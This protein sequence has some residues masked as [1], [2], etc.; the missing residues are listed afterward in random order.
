MN[1]LFSPGCR[2]CPSFRRRRGWGEGGCAWG[3]QR[4]ALRGAATAPRGRHSPS[5]ELRR[6]RTLGR[7]A[8]AGPSSRTGRGRPRDPE[9]PLLSAPA[10]GSACLALSAPQNE[11]SL[12]AGRHSRACAGP[13]SQP[14]PAAEQPEPG[15]ARRKGTSAEPRRSLFFTVTKCFPSVK[16]IQW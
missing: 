3:E 2:I 7:D 16:A 4:A 8:G 11:A 12:S 10:E 6:S 13:G 1:E 14:T 5:A 15:A 9:R